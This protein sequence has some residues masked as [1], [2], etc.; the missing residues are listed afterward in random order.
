MRTL[1]ILAAA[2]FALPALAADKDLEPAKEIK[3]SLFDNKDLPKLKEAPASG[4]VTDE[5]EFAK[6]WGSWR[7]G[8]PLPKVDFKKQLVYVVAK[9]GGFTKIIGGFKLTDQG[10]LQPFFA[11]SEAAG[12]GFIFKMFVLDREGVKTVNGKALP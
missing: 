8:D 3:G 6:L 10:D 7:A 9:E 11:F 1:A 5:K 2:C 12:P 4:V